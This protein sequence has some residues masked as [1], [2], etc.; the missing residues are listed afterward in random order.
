MPTKQ[1]A[2]MSYQLFGN[3]LNRKLTNVEFGIL[4]K[5]SFGQIINL[6][7]QANVF[8]F[9]ISSLILAFTSSALTCI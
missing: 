9:S 8:S 1:I 6:T 3:H 2:T 7:N 5:H 4:E